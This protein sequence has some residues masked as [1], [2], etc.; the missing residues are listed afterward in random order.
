MNITQTAGRLADLQRRVTAR[1]LDVLP[2]TF[3]QQT[4]NRLRFTQALEG[5]KDAMAIGAAQELGIFTLLA[6]GGRTAA[7][8]AEGIGAPEHNTDVLLRSLE[9]I[10]LLRRS[11]KKYENTY[12]A[13]Q[14]DEPDAWNSWR[15]QVD[16]MLGSWNAWRELAEAVRAGDGHEEIRVY[17]E[18]NPLTGEYARMSISMLS[19]PSKELVRR[20]D[21]APVRRMIAGTVG[22]SFVRAVLDEK[23]DVEVTIS[24]LPQL[25]R[26]LPEALERYGLPRPE[27]VIENS[28]DAEADS[29]GESEEFDLVFLARK[30]AYCG[31][32]HAEAYLTKTREVISEDGMLVVW[33]PLRENY[34]IIPGMVERIALTD[35]MMGEGH[36]LYDKGTIQHHM[37]RAGFEVDV[38]DVSDGLFTFFVGH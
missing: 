10:G 34:S 7:Q 23:P 3:V 37:R 30:F 18:D 13:A 19:R 15:A 2:H 27:N 26:V 21:L 20:L 14:L 17:N 24:C 8:I 22:T 32:D 12:I 38:H 9:S 36:P 35:M 1:L 4:Y 11:G 33:E 31:L 6:S 25:I 29:W 5:Y 16:I 28:G